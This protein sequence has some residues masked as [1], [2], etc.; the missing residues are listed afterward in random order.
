MPT[1]EEG[2]PG[3]GETTRTG[4]GPVDQPGDQRR[5]GRDLLGVDLEPGEHVPARTAGHGE[6]PEVG[7]R[8]IPAGVDVDAAGAGDVPEH[9]EVARRL[10][11]ERRG[12]GEPVGDDGVAERERSDLGHVGGDRREPGRVRQGEQRRAAFS[13]RARRLTEIRRVGLNRG[14]P[15]G[16]RRRVRLSDTAEGSSS[17]VAHASPIHDRRSNNHTMSE[18]AKFFNSSPVHPLRAIRRGLPY[19]VS[20]GA[21]SW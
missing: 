13:G 19:G 20:D 21:E 10:E 14:F 5:G 15:G 9:T 18:I 4:A 8:V 2:R 12:A 7:E 11:G 6:R 1:P 16:T 3:L 17:E